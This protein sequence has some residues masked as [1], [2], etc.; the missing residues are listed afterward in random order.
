MQEADNILRILKETQEAIEEKNSYRIKQLSD[1]TMHSAAVYQDPDN[2][3]VAVIVYAI[4]KIIEREHYRELPGWEDFYKSLMED[5][6]GAIK[7]IENEK[8]ENFRD[9]EKRIRVSI[10]EIDGKL[11]DYVEDVLRKAQINKASKIYEHGLSMEKTADLLGVSL[12]EL[13]QYIGQSHAG[14]F[15][16]TFSVK[17]RVKLAEEIFS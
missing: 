9:I 17:K 5:I 1:Q 8:I 6:S 14:E 4:S 13:S 15:S 11:K 3:I 10:E 2:I 7:A 12:W 16:E